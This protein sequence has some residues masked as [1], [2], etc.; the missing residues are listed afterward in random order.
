MKKFS[1]IILSFI[2]TL[3]SVFGLIGCN[4]KIASKTD[5]NHKVEITT[6]NKTFLSEG[7]SEYKIVIPASADSKELMASAELQTLFKEATGWILPVV[8]DEDLQQVDY[9]TDKYIFIG[10]TSFAVSEELLPNKAKYGRSGY[11]IKSMGD[12]L[13]II[14]SYSNGTLYGV[15]R[16]LEYILDYDYYGFEIYSMKTGIAD[17]KLKNF[18][19]SI[20]Y[21]IDFSR[22]VY[23]YT[24]NNT[25]NLKHSVQSLP[26]VPVNGQT[27]HSSIYWF[28]R[29]IY[30]DQ[31][32]N[33]DTYHP[34]WFQDDWESQYL[35]TELRYQLCFTAHGEDTYDEM[36]GV[37]AGQIK[38]KIME[39]ED[40]YVFD[41]SMS[42]KDTW[43][44]CD[45]CEA[46]INKYGGAKS[47][48]QVLFLNDVC[49]NV[50]AWFDT[51]EG[52]PYTCEYLVKF[53]AYLC[54]TQAPEPVDKDIYLSR[55]LCPIIADVNMDITS[56][57][58]ASDNKSTTLLYTGWGKISKNIAA[59]TY[60]CRYDEYISPIEI[61]N[62]MQAWYR[63]YDSQNVSSIWNLGNCYEM[64]F[65]TG[66][67]NLNVY[68]S[69]KLACD[70][71]VN[72]NDYIKKY[73]KNVYK[74]AGET[75][76]TMFNE[77]RARDEYNSNMENPPAPYAGSLAN[78]KDIC[79]PE[80]FPKSVLNRWMDL[81]EQALNDIEYLKQTN[82]AE[83]NVIKKMIIGERVA[84]DYIYFDTYDT[85]PKAELNVVAQR[86]IDDIKF[87]GVTR[88]REGGEPRDIND[89]IDQFVKGA[90]A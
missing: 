28:D 40:N 82:E 81:F 31:T 48:T 30:L 68:L 29:D 33:P 77:W 85:L 73:F 79:F 66:W 9:K 56:S 75:M 7:K 42:D 72:V 25:Y 12:C 21:D 22:M 18:D 32:K 26:T 23:G 4:D 1:I 16:Y 71:D 54:T 74:D 13:F 15:Y 90:I 34:E 53:Y 64:G 63:F 78:Y 84:Y 44:P 2:I 50:D 89:Y 57:P 69:S 24:N 51:E 60:C 5:G 43:C 27:G 46:V 11:I 80:F 49:A 39:S 8:E 38:E 52:K 6:T 83:Y 37:M 17:M 45:A 55:R 70:V 36:V 65:A 59:Y 19:V 87:A 20:I 67:G 58:Y 47:A 61:I 88:F 35:G 41:C 86:L 76:L 14:G 3:T 62:D 10:E